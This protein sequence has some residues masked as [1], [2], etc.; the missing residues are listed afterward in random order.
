[1]YFSTIDI[2]IDF[3]FHAFWSVVVKITI[4]QKQEHPLWGCKILTKNMGLGP[5]LE[6]RGSETHKKSVGTGTTVNL[7]RLSNTIS[8]TISSVCHFFNTVLFNSL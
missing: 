3:Q 5:K 2:K 4:K 8:L 6:N 7:P 1:M